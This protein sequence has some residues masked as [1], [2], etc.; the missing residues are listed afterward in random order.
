MAYLKLFSLMALTAIKSTALSTPAQPSLTT[1]A[2]G[3]TTPSHLPLNTSLSELLTVDGRQVCTNDARWQLPG[4]PGAG[5]YTHACYLALRGII[6]QEF[7][8]SVPSRF[9][10]ATSSDDFPEATV[11]TPKRYTYSRKTQ[12]QTFKAD[13]MIS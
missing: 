11:R 8:S 13:T 1:T 6:N 12:F 2:V 9:L 5:S 3:A 10:S 4:G 7:I